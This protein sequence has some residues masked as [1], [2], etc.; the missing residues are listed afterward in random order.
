MAARY[1]IAYSPAH[2]QGILRR[3]AGMPVSRQAPLEVVVR[4]PRKEKT[5]DQRRLWHAM[6]SEFASHTGMTPAEAKGVVKAEYF[7]PEPMT[8][9]S[10]HVVQ[11]VRESSEDLDRE[12]YSRLI[13]FTAQ[14]AAE[15]GVVLSDRRK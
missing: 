5:G 2:L 12:Q 15:H 3:I 10:G 6:L 1:F 7:G 13:D 11:V 14:F 8:L 9:P 4:P